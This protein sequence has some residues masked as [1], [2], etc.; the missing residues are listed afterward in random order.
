MVYVALRR[1]LQ[2][3]KAIA[4]LLLTNSHSKIRTY[5]IIFVLGKH[6]EELF[7]KEN[8]LIGHVFELMNVAVCI[9]VAEA[10][11]HRIIDEKNVG[12][13]IPGSIIIP[14]GRFIL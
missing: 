10:C 11:S 12:E 13:L 5:I 3:Y 2:Q 1:T 14:K 6:L 9:D 7:E 8:H 4:T